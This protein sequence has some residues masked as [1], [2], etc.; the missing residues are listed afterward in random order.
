[1]LEASY[2]DDTDWIL[3]HWGRAG[4]GSGGYAH[5]STDATGDIHLVNCQSHNDD[6]RSVPLYAA[7]CAGCMGE[8]ANSWLVDDELYAGHRHRA[9]SGNRTLQNL[10]INPLLDRLAK[11]NQPITYPPTR[12]IQFTSPTHLR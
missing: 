8:E 5:W 4:E 2:P 6:W 3:H 10:Y 1:M 9:L 11:Q 7:I 12:T